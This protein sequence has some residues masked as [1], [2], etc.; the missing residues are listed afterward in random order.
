[1]GEP[2]SET[3]FA[4]VTEFGRTAPITGNDGSDHGTKMVALLAGG[5]LKGGRVVSDW[6]GRPTS[7]TSAT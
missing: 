5:A 6:P 4:L 3:I 2:W 1:M 7:T